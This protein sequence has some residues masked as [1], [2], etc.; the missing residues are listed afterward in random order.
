MDEFKLSLANYFVEERNDHRNKVLKW[1]SLI[2]YAKNMFKNS[3]DFDD[4]FEDLC[5]FVQS[6]LF[7]DEECSLAFS[8]QTII[9]YCFHMY[10][11]ALMCFI[12]K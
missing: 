9:D 5:D 2:I 8:K 3:K 7:S 1:S 12:L 4:R 6:K 10:S 11:A